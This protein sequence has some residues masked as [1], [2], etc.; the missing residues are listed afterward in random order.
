[1]RR[2]QKGTLSLRPS[3]LIRAGLVLFSLFFLLGAPAIAAGPDENLLAKVK[4]LETHLTQ[5]ESDQKTILEQQQEILAQ[6]E[7]LRVWVRR[8]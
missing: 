6:L 5:I 1:M 3:P 4:Q 7:T 2:L 8:S